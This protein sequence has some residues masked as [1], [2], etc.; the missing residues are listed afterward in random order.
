MFTIEKESISRATKRLRDVLG[1]YLITVIAFGSRVRGDLTG[2]SDFD[3]LV[4]VKKRDF[5]II[6][7]VLTPAPQTLD[8]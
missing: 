8:Q 7:T 6:E 3:I 5:D 4:V 2:E 1:N